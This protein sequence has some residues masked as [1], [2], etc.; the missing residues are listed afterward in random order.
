MSICLVHCNF[1]TLGTFLVFYFFAKI[2]KNYQ[3]EE[4]S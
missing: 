3:K 1:K 2:K 4:Q